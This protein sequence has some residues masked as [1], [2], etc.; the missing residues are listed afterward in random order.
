MNE[1]QTGNYQ[2]SQKDWGGEFE[3]TALPRDQ[4]DHT[5]GKAGPSWQK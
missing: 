3:D 1:P 5:P 4:S 2:T